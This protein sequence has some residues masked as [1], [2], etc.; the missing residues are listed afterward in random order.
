MSLEVIAVIVAAASGIFTLIGTA[1]LLAWF[2]SKE[3]EKINQSFWS[4][5][6]TATDKIVG[7]LEYH[8]QHDDA[9]FEAN[10][11]RHQATSD[12]IWSIELRNAAKD[13]TLPREYPKN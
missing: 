7:K 5:L 11:K 6:N 1:A 8:E 2:A 12:R 10:E 9:R 13:G 3:F 4:A